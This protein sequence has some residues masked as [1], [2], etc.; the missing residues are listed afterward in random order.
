MMRALYVGTDTQDRP[1]PPT[2][3]LAV[4]STSEPA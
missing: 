4:Q 2:A 3:D 1:F